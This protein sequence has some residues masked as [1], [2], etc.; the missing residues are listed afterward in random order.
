M[1]MKNTEVKN[2]R[3]ISFKEESDYNYTFYS[4]SHEKE[5]SADFN[6]LREHNDGC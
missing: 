6:Y 3:L 1:M 4:Q 2:G 5:D